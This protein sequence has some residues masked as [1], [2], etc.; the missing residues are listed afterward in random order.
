MNATGESAPTGLKPLTIA[1]RDVVLADD[2]RLLVGAGAGSGKTSTVVQKLC[3]LL[4][5]RV[6]DVTGAQ[7][8]QAT[9]L[10]L[11]DIAAITFTNEAAADLK[12][13]LRAALVASG[14]RHLAPDVDTARIGT[15]HGFCGD[16]L[17]EFALRA[18]LPPS[19]LVLADGEAAAL[20]YECAQR[21]VHR[22]ATEQH[23]PEFA[24]LLADR[25]L[26]D[27]VSH[28]ATVASDSDRLAAWSGRGSAVNSGGLR[29]HER[30]LLRLAQDARL[31]REEELTRLGAM[32]FDRMIV[33]VRDLLRVDARVRRAVQRQIRLLI[34]DEFQDVDP[35]QRDLAF[36]LGGLEF[37]DPSPTR[38]MLVGDPKQSIYKFRRADVSLWNAVAAQFSAQQLGRQLELSDN[39]RS[40]AGMLALVDLSVGVR[41][42]TPV[43]ADGGRQSFEVDYRALVAKGSEAAGDRCVEMIAIAA[44]ADGST[45]KA[46]AL[47][48]IEAVAVAE[49]MHALHEGGERYG[50]MAMLLSSFTAVHLYRDALRARGIPVYVL[51]GEGYWETRE[52]VDCLLALRAIR[53]PAD[54]VAL[55]GFLRGPFVGV[56]DETLLA[57]RSA[58]HPGGLRGALAGSAYESALCQRAD[59]LLTRFAALRDRVAVHELLSRLVRE[60]G[61]LA[62]LVQ[63]DDRG[64]QA[65]ANMRKLLRVTGA[66][67]ELSLGEFL[68]QVREAR[69]RCDRVGEERLY[70][71]RADVV[72]ITTVHSAKGLEWPVVFWCD[73][74]REATANHDKLQMGRDLFRLRLESGEEDEEGKVVDLAHDALKAELRE[75]QLAE[76]FR[77]WYVATTRSQR[78]LVLSGVPLGEKWRQSVSMANEL[79]ERFPLLCSATDACAISYAHASGSAYELMLRVVTGEME[80]AKTAAE[81]KTVGIDLHVLRPP[82]AIGAP[83][84]RTRLSATQLMTFASDDAI[85]WRRYVF[86]FE[87]DG[88]YAQRRGAGSTS[89]RGLVVHDVLERFNYELADIDEL[90]ESAIER[91]D[92]DA[93]A[94]FSAAGHGYRQR[95]R[96]MVE[97]ATANPEWQAVSQGPTARRELTFARVLPDGSVIDGALDLIAMR[98]GAARILDLKTGATTDGD[99]L[100]ERYRVQAAVYSEAVRAIAGVDTRLALLST[101]DGRTI[102][103][104]ASGVDLAELLAKLRGGAS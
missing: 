88:T 25:S 82:T 54:D 57:L 48:A 76:Q 30:A 52:V 22:A 10:A 63:D 91:H 40:R 85:W 93:P 7:H 15:I 9:P 102:E 56:R 103:V 55:V 104:D 86:G 29:D 61:F 39:F 51:R 50:D 28:V 78:L 41:L 49:R 12:R 46:D 75:E 94:P 92:P 37:D 4:G 95:I 20:A 27:I 1:Q 67:P 74:A 98:G 32:D 2:M 99:V 65:L 24:H 13:K 59:A 62:V 47:R 33:S 44:P 23:V 84:G 80:F 18:G 60:T 70:R 87:P 83:R 66:S 77:L 14:L 8:E 38:I 71:E 72:T 69:E 42:D 53:D 81:G 45:H 73:L 26:A 97:S 5:G 34:V 101:S 89:A 43:R 3:Y 96:A 21:A 36:L 11:S 6:S 16:L 19:L 64:T 79:R 68:R 100:A 17:R 31:V 90:I 58:Q 35:A